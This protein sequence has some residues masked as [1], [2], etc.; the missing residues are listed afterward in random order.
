M[1]PQGLGAALQNDRA[2]IALL[3]A[4]AVCRP[5]KP[6]IMSAHTARP[7]A[8]SV[9][10]G[11]Y[12]H[13]EATFETVKSMPMIDEQAAVLALTQ[14]THDGPWHDT[15]RAVAAAG[16]ALKLLDG[17]IGDLHD[18]DRA[19]AAVI[20]GRVGSAD[21]DRAR[22]LIAAMRSLGVRLVTV[23]D[24]EYPGNMFWTNDYQPFLWVRGPIA[25]DGH[26]VV[27]VVGEHDHEQ[28]A[29]AARALADAGLT[30]V[31]PVHTACGATVLQSA[32]AAG[33][34]TLGVLDEG[35]SRPP[36]R[37]ANVTRRVAERGALV[38]AFWPETV[39]G[40]RTAALTPI[41]T[42]GLAALLYV[43][44]GRGDGFSHRHVTKA[45][46][47]GK[48]VFV[49]QRLHREQPWVAEAGFRGGITA[50][51]DTDDL[52]TQAVKVVDMDS[53]ATMF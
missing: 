12:V 4:N 16:S 30:V 2:G 51:Q 15:A 21:L 7:V 40:E 27:A 43:A 18:D 28:A 11:A 9:G 34:R 1:R 46:R 14:A 24:E 13:T 23:L 38:S 19:H 41:V 37:Y 25:L 8:A 50:V 44:D 5:P 33:G 48:H 10:V 3:S 6:G 45:L 47:T 32:A 49:P 53:R 31:A 39:A 26:R 42:C 52:C 29:A 36:G 35:L 22:K 17:D 20:R